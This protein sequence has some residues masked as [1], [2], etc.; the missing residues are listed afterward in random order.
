MPFPVLPFR[1]FSSIWL[2]PG[3]T[4]NIAIPIYYHRPI[5]DHGL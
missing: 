1:L 4:L 5:L 3:L 2:L